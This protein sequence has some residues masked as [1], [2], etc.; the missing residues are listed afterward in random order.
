M[1]LI[2]G[3]DICE[4]IALDQE[5]PEGR[6]LSSQASLSLQALTHARCLVKSARP[7]NGMVSRYLH[8]EAAQGREVALHLSAHS[9]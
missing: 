2:I 6:S 5:L 4:T 7:A 3:S 1:T 9:A 8:H